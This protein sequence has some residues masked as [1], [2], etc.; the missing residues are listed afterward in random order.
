MRIIVQKFGGT[1][2]ADK[3]RRHA[4]IDKVV[5]AIEAGYSP[6]VVVSAIGRKGDPYATDTLLSLINSKASE[7]AMEIENRDID[8]LM[9]CGEIISSVVMAKEFAERGYKTQVLTG[10]NAGIVTD[11]NFGNAA[12]TMVNPDKLL[13]I[14]KKG[15][16]P[17]VA[18]FQGVTPEGEFT[19]LGRGGS[20]V[21]GAVIGEA[22]RADCIEIYT[23]VDGIMTADPRIV[24]DAR[25]ID[26]ISFNEV[27]QLADQGAKVIHP[28]AVEYAM[29]GNVPLIIK[30][31]LSDAK[32]TTITSSREYTNKIITGI[33]HM[34]NRSQIII[35]FEGAADIESNDVFNVLAEHDICI[36][37]INV[38]SDKKI[39]TVD[40]YDRVKVE[41]VLR[42]L[43]LNYRIIDNC[44][45][46]AV[47]GSRL[48]F[49]PGVMAKILKSLRGNNIEVLQTAD[50]HTTVW[51]LVN[52][53]DTVQAINTLHR[54]FCL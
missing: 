49:I 28:R 48:R 25:L 9:S 34:S 13:K 39:F 47:I 19:T 12:I 3:Q 20:D 50:S 10:G 32:G 40:G 27:F 17:I 30:N 15:I 46:I 35:D 42:N 33:T 43:K 52:G 5:A 8:L 37:L 41:E 44:S 31:S 4:S 7:T 24:P 21:T 18:G 23:D 6:V 36:E 14:L 38:F 45:K 11:S 51:C 54:E 16:I 53:E 29:Y 26:T 2:V 22:L 1:S